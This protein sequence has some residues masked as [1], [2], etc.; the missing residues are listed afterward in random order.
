MSIRLT[1]CLYFALQGIAVVAWW[2]MLI[3]V[4]STRV[5]FLMGDN[6]ETVL[7]A[8]WLP[9][10]FLIAAGSVAASVLCYLKSK[11]IPVA[12]WF[13]CGAVSY[14]AL[15]CLAFAFLTDKGWRGVTLM[16]PA[17]LWSGVFSVGLLP[18]KEFMFRQAKPAQT[19]WIL[20][21]TALQIIV[22]WT[23]VLFVFPYFIVQLEDKLGIPR[24]A[25]PFQKAFSAIFFV[26]ISLLG[27]SGAYTMSQ[28]GKG[29]PLPLDSASKLVVKGIYSYVRN[30]MAI[31]GIGQG[32]AVGLFLGSPLVLIYALTG[33]LIWQ[34]IFRQ[35][36][37]EDLLTRFG[38]DY[39]DY[40]Q[41][42]SCWIPRFKP[43]K[44]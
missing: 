13:V 3:F 1:A 32:I 35:L 21:K 34:L 44:K 41:N 30:P 22:V 20:T 33:G 9:D 31:S 43:Y 6:S 25:F 26:S 7:L 27:L 36:E 40:R 12:L 28:I 14:A 4:P 10:L 8:F 38:T 17:M 2:L 18:A 15:Y 11:F 42:V 16:L 19:N 23:L 5:Y 29:T 39:E 24:F 37:E